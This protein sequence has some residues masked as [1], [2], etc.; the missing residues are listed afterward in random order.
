MKKPIIIIGC[1]VTAI[2][3]WFV[4]ASQFGPTSKREIEKTVERLRQDSIALQSDFRP[5]GSYEYCQDID[6]A[7]SDIRDLVDPLRFGRTEVDSTRLFGNPQTAAIAN[8]NIA[9]CDTVLNKTLPQWRRTFALTLQKQLN[10]DAQTIV[11]IPQGSNDATTL[12]IYSLRYLSKDNIE[13]DAREYNTMLRNLG[14][15]AVLFTASPD[16]EG[17]KYTL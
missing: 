17:M 2:V 4:A 16:N 8:Y 15:K 11:R 14:F 1:V 10:K 6:K 9:K 12:E 7:V 13:N 5:T 3:L